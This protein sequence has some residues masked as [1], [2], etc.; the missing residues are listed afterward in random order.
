M[1][2]R[3]MLS[4]VAA[5]LASLPGSRVTTS[6]HPEQE[7]LDLPGVSMWTRQ[8]G[9]HEGLAEAA[10]NHDRVLL[11]APEIGGL[12][13]ELAGVVE[14]AG[15]TLLGPSAGEIRR[16][17]DKLAIAEMLGSQGI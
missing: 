15:G 12:L 13:A 11:I 8:G 14:G 9:L 3:A 17:S 7:L 10:R 4:R 16:L 2:G 1:E 5:D 6:V